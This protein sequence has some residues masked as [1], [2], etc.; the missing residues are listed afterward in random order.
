MKSNLLISSVMD[1]AFDVV[2]KTYTK[3]QYIQLIYKLI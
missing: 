2:Y 1:C 3:Q